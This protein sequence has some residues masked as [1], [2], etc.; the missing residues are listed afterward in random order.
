MKTCQSRKSLLIL[1]FLG[2]SLYSQ[3]Q[4]SYF[5]I[6]IE[7]K[8]GI[9]RSDYPSVNKV[10]KFSPA[11]EA[12]I[13]AGDIIWS[14][15][16]KNMI[17]VSAQKLSS[18][19]LEGDGEVRTLV[20][21]SDKRQVK[22]TTRPIIGK[23]TEGD[24]Q[25]GEGRFEDPSGN[26]Y[27]GGFFNGK[28]EDLGEYWGK[29]GD[30][31]HYYY[32]G[33]MVEGKREGA[34]MML[35]LQY[36]YRY[37]GYFRA[38]LFSGKG[39]LSF[40]KSNAVYD[41]YFSK[42]LPLGPGIMTLQTGET[43]QISPAT[44]AELYAAARQDMK[45]PELTHQKSWTDLTKQMQETEQVLV[46]MLNDYTL[47]YQKYQ[48]ANQKYNNAYV[49]ETYSASSFNNFIQNRDKAHNLF[50]KCKN[51]AFETNLTERD[52]KSLEGWLEELTMIIKTIQIGEGGEATSQASAYHQNYNIDQINEGILKAK[53]YRQAN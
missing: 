39:H 52:V 51:T 21:G 6:G 31:I 53:M 46:N 11:E 14:V 40:E 36:G 34:G 26:I 7:I 37:S 17:G 15:D 16:G 45:K 49:V 19:I 9:T 8:G 25:N 12:N 23:C 43:K 5:G 35:N 24:C 50:F 18:Y 38:N 44:W 2:I 27:Q 42:D 1:T 20:L 13:I 32:K 30:T 4:F 3:A 10:F 22:L 48:E 41:G 47:F 28:F 33:Q 29:N